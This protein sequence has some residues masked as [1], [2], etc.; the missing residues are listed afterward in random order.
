MPLSS[1]KLAAE[2]LVDRVDHVELAG[3]PLGAQ[4]VGDLEPRRVVG[5]HEVVV[6]EL[7]RGERHL[8]DRRAA[9]GPVGVGVQVAAERGPDLAAAGGQR[10]GLLVLEPGQPLGHLAAP[11]RRSITCA[12]LLPMPG[13]VG[14]RAGRRRARETS[15]AGIGST[16]AAALR[17]ALTLKVSS[18]AALEQE[19]DPPQRG[20]RP[21]GVLLGPSDGPWLAPRGTG[22]IPPEFLSLHTLLHSIVPGQ[23]PVGDPPGRCPQP[24]P[25]DVPQ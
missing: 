11:R 10:P 20:D 21:V 1:R 25:E 13:Q 12:E 8:L 22:T 9:V 14:Q 16:V 4:P 18:R 7:D 23:R 3:Q 2:V 5:E 17:N 19:R 15:S 24:H 6:A